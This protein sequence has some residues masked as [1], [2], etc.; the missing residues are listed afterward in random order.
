MTLGFLFACKIKEN[1][2]EAD[3]FW[4][5]KRRK[6]YIY[7][8]YGIRENPICKML[9]HETYANLFIIT[10]ILLKANIK[11]WTYSLWKV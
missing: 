4:M 2:V 9:S 8:K 10:W 7:I 11:C 5:R 3:I 1:Y 6:K